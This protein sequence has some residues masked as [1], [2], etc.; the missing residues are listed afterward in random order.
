MI[1]YKDRTYCNAGVLCRDWDC[2]RRVQQTDIVEARKL[3][4]PICCINFATAKCFVPFFQINAPSK[5]EAKRRAAGYMALKD[6][7]DVHDV[8]IQKRKKRKSYGKSNTTV[9]PISSSKYIK[10]VCFGKKRTTKRRTGRG[11]MCHY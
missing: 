4:L 10:P 9:C 6:V 7:G 2:D 1:H 3:D 8:T 5:S 11:V